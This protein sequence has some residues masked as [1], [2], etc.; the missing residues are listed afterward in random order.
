MS[1]TKMT[2]EEFLAY[3]REHIGQYC[4][5]QYWQCKYNQLADKSVEGIKKEVPFMAINA[6]ATDYAYRHG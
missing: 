4:K 2:F 3:V 5:D 1:E 6:I